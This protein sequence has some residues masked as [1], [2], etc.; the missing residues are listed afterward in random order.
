VRADGALLRAAAI[1]ERGQR[2]VVAA[3]VRGRVELE[4]RVRAAGATA[5]DHADWGSARVRCDP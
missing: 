3:D 5:F 1:A 4:L 2:R